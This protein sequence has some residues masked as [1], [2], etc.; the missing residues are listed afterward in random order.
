MLI[1]KQVLTQY[2]EVK[3]SPQQLLFLEPSTLR[4]ISYSSDKREK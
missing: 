4:Q 3:P 1:F 2:H